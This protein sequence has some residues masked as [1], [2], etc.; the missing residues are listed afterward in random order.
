MVSRKGQKERKCLMR[1]TMIGV[2]DYGL[3]I[4]FVLAIFVIILVLPP[5]R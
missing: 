2:L 3:A 4:A 5:R 1:L